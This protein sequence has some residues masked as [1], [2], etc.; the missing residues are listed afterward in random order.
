MKKEFAAMAVVI[1]VALITGC[2]STMRG[3]PPRMLPADLVT[4][5]EVETAAKTL[6]SG[7]ND[8]QANKIERNKNISLLVSAAD[9]RFYEFRRDILANARHSSAGSG[10]LTL[11]MSIAGSM[12]GSPGVK[13]HYLLGTNLVNGVSSQYGQSYLHEKSV[14]ALIATMDADRSAQLIV[15]LNG[16]EDSEYRGQ[17]ALLDLYKYL[18]AGTIESAVE[19]IERHAKENAQINGLIASSGPAERKK[20]ADG[21]IGEQIAD[22][23]SVV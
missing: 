19:S 21:I 16:M 13:Q 7:V 3:G 11:L 6:A 18:S 23:K 20:F 5:T 17:T 2:V 15:I 1:N 9:A 14:A 8:G 10:I 12:T 22:R 4:K